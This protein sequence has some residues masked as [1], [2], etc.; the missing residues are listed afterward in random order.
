MVSILV[1]VERPQ[2]TGDS[3]T[4]CA[5]HGKESYSLLAMLLSRPAHK[6][7]ETTDGTPQARSEARY[8]QLG[9]G[10]QLVRA[11]VTQES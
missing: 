4:A 6:E 11:T 8:E 2:P 5:R 10:L 1:V 7:W 3:I 9:D